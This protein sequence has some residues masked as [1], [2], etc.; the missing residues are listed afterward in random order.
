MRCNALIC[1]AVRLPC[2]RLPDAMTSQTPVQAR[3]GD[4][5]VDEFSDDR[6]ETIQ[7]QHQHL[8]Q[9]H[10]QNLLSRGQGGLKRVCRVRPILNAVSVFP[11]ADGAFRDPYLPCQFG[12][13]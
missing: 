6:Q 12:D 4:I 5:W 11:G 7:R 8:T 13:R 1:K 9:F 10:H 2:L 3:T